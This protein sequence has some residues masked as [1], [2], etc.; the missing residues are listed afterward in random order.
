MRKTQLGVMVFI[1]V[2]TGVFFTAPVR[3]W[4]ITANPS[5]Y[6]FY[7]VYIGESATMTGSI[8]NDPEGYMVNITDY[9]WIYNPLG[10]F[11]VT[12]GVTVPYPFPRGA[13]R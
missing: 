10:A 11:Q 4:H 3:A 9:E 6:D 8:T 5:T 12:S 2:L 13:G 1:V 7:T